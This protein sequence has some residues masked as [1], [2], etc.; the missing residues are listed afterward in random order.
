MKT[1]P[2]IWNSVFGE[3]VLISTQVRY[4]CDV[5]KQQKNQIFFAR[6]QKDCLDALDY[7]L[8]LTVLAFLLK[9]SLLICR[10]LVNLNEG[11]DIKLFLA[12]SGVTFGDRGAFSLVVW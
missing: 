6:H 2:C 11:A 4:H 7:V 1:Y 5:C 9:V 8:Q 12:I 3:H 10:G